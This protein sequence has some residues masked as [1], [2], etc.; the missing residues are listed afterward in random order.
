MNQSR[1]NSGRPFNP[2][3]S[4]PDFRAPIAPEVVAKPDFQRFP[5]LEQ[6][7]DQQ[8]PHPFLRLSEPP[9]RRSPTHGLLQEL[10]GGRLEVLIADAERHPDRYDEDTKDLLEILA[11]GTKTIEKLNPTEQL[12]LNRAVIDYAAFKPRAKPKPPAPPKVKA[13]EVVVP[14]DEEAAESEPENHQHD[15]GGPLSNY[16]WLT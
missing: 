4:F 12:L 11:A 5:S 6:L 1:N 15:P 16:W 8:N 9:P 13:A 14:F 2:A 10:L 7:L 3:D